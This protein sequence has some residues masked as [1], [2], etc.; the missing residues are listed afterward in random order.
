MERVQGVK[1]S[2]VKRQD[3]KAVGARSPRPHPA[4]IK[5]GWGWGIKGGFKRWPDFMSY[6]AGYFLYSYLG[7]SSPLTERGDLKKRDNCDHS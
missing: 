4:L 1:G 3:Q 7:S 5:K 2:R 6:W